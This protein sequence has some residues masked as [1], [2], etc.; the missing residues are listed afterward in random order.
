MTKKDKK[1]LGVEKINSLT[2]EL[3]IPWFAIG[4]INKN[5]I[6]TLRKWGFKKVALVSELMN[7]QD[8]KREAIIILKR[9]SYEN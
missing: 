3:K 8:P 2:K 7:A 6:P 5:N 9:L 4:G 1:Q